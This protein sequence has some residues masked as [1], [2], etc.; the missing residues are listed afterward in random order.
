MLK[1]KYQINYFQVTESNQEDEDNDASPAE[2]SS[3]KNEGI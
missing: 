1:Y 2:K 3:R